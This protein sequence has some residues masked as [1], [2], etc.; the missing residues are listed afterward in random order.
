MTMDAAFDQL[1]TRLRAGDQGAAA[2][3]FDR[4]A[5]RLIGLARACLDRRLRRKVDPEDVVQSVYKSFFFRQAQGQFNPSD[6]DNLW[7]L[8][9]VITVRKCGRWKM[10]F[11]SQKRDINSELTP[12]P[13]LDDSTPDWE[14]LAD[15]PTPA[16]AAILNETL[17]CLLRSL[18]GRDRDIVSLSLQGYSPVEI[19]KELGRPRRT[20]FRVLAR[21]KKRLEA[22]R[23]A[24]MAS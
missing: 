22:M 1:M 2:Q 16:E 6:W 18:E 4:F 24:E 17:E 21:V 11:L 10:H 12:P 23:T 8:L 15:D 3:V 14:A 13:G 19:S 5:N 20:V 9:T 7:S